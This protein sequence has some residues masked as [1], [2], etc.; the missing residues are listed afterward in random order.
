MRVGFEV[1]FARVIEDGYRFEGRTTAIEAGQPWS[2]EYVIVVDST[3]VTLRAEVAELTS[4]GSRRLDL[5]HDGAGRWRVDSAPA[6]NLDG[7][8][9]VDL[10][11]SAF[12]NA[13]PVHRLAPE[14]GEGARAIAACVAAPGLDVAVLD[15]R[16]E[17]RPDAGGHRCF[18][19][20]APELDF[21]AELRYDESGLVAEYP[22][23]ASRVL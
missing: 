6:P 20:T 1:V 15:Q 11:A 12:T 8:L 5:E 17:R 9:D 23:L 14:V 4:T 19:Y 16:Y 10:E 13:L 22:G 2:A 7:C 3:W 21:A 18:A